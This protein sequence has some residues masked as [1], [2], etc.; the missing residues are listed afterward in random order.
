MDLIGLMNIAVP[1]VAG[2]VYFFMAAEIGRVS[3]VRRI[4]FGEIGYK[5]V[6]TAFLMLGVYFFTRPLQNLLGP[7]P[8]PLIINC[9]RQFF[10]MAVIAP[11]ILV[12][13]FHWVPNEEKVTTRSAAVASYVVGIL[14]ATV[15]ILINS[16]A[17]DGSK[18][19]ADWGFVRIYDAT[20]FAKKDA[21]VEI[22]LVHLISQLISPVGFFLLAAAYVRHRRHNYNLGHIY[23]LMPLKWRLLEAGLLIFALSMIL[24]GVAAFIGQYYTYLWVIYFVGAIVAGMLELKGIKI[25]PRES[26]EDLK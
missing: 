12:G 18:I 13:I 6:F 4:M 9:A 8:W 11:A 14:M 3:K 5:K 15:F 7:H 24:A 20:W 23:N 10:L 2:L 19:L 17:I 21:R 26:P 22:V 25:P 16:I 1:V